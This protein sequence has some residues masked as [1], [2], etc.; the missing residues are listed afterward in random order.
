MKVNKKD[1][2]YI[3][4]LWPQLKVAINVYEAGNIYFNIKTLDGFRIYEYGNIRFIKKGNEILIEVK[5]LLN[6]GYCLVYTRFNNKAKF[7]KAYGYEIVT[8]SK[9]LY[10]ELD[11]DGNIKD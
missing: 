3:K 8:K 6:K 4:E 7:K 2:Q 5:K 1:I 9:E 10:V 11:E